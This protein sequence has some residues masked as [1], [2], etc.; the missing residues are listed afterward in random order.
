MQTELKEVA[1]KIRRDIIEEV[2]SAQ[3]GHPG[4]SLSCADILTVLYFKVMN[5]DPKDPC[6]PGRDRLIMSKGHA[7]P[8]L[9]AAMA[10]RGYFPTEELTTFRKIGSRLQGHPDMETLPGVDM[11]T[12]SLGQGI[13]AAVGMALAGKLD[14]ASYRVYAVLGDGEL[15]EGLVWEAA[16]AAGHYK[17]DHLCAIVDNNGLQ[18]D[19]PNDEVMT[20]EP[21]G[22]KFR[23]FGWNVICCD[24]HDTDQLAEAFEKAKAFEG[25]P[26]VIIA[27]TVKGKGVSF[28]ENQAGWHGKAPNKE[29]AEKAEK[30]LGGEK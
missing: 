19:G 22:D 11:S 24:G 23:S 28:M 9:Y 2:Y 14:G 10:E 30:E 6:A 5:I 12:G 8:A 27:S 15:Q 17:L 29:Q 4:G 20:V 18:I 26:S 3:S 1:A 21:I 13:S 16:M 25:K 7:T